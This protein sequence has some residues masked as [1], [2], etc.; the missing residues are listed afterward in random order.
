MVYNDVSLVSYIQLVFSGYCIEYWI[1][2][3][4]SD[5]ILSWILNISNLA[6]VNTELRS[7]YLESALGGYC[8][9]YWI[10]NFRVSCKLN[11]NTSVHAY[12]E[13]NTEYEYIV[14]IQTPP[15]YWIPTNVGYSR[16]IWILNTS[17]YSIFNSVYMHT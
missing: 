16:W 2:C 14:H 5:W 11:M 8:V 17:R 13:L 12:C 4:T 10:S 6:A 9:A 1:P 7:E 15:E 3:I